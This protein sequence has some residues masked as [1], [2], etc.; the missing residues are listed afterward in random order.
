MEFNLKK[1]NKVSFGFSFFILAAILSIVFY[2][3]FSENFRV[4]TSQMTIMFIP[5]SET[6]AFNSSAIMENLV[7]FPKF[8]SF[9]DRLFS[10]NNNLKDQFS[11][12]SQDSRKKMWN[13]AMNISKDDGST[14]LK[15]E[16]TLKNREQSIL[17]AKQT[18]RTLFDTA[19]FYY[20]IKTDADFRVVDGP[21]T[22]AITKSWYWLVL[23][24]IFLGL[25]VSFILNFIFSNFADSLA[26]SKNIFIK[27]TP[28]QEMQ[29]FS[30]P[31]TKSSK[32]P[33]ETLGVTEKRYQAPPNLPIA[34]ETD[35]VYSE[36]L[37][38]IP[39]AM[40]VE[41]AP[42]LKPQEM[43]EPTDAE[44]KKRLNQLLRGEI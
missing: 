10:L 28:A 7:R 4:Y 41:T 27:K 13:Q 37:S 23:L 31:E 16:V 8:L 38:Q 22:V 26:N 32:I 15:I 35:Q 1:I 18:A 30:E 36:D 34:P 42:E 20:N 2:L 25:A 9:Y 3:I 40:D 29:Q 24:S 19:S 11:G 44:L 17:F 14:M 33:F 12:L 5:K 39:P 6:A 43:P 21:V